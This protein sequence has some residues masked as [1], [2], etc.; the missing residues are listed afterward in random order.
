MSDV[1]VSYARPAER[2]AQQ[3]TDLL[4]SSGYSVWRDD[5]LPA[6]RTY[7]EVIEERLASAKAVLVL[8]SAD[9]FKSQWVRAEADIA[10]EAGTLVQ[11]TVDGK[12]PPLPFN[13]IQCAN[14]QNWN[15]NAEAAE[16]KKVEGSIASL[17]RATG[18]GSSPE[19][20]MD[21]KN[22]SIC[23]LPFENMS[24]DA[25]Q[26][27]FSD[28]I[29]EDIITDLSK[30]AAL[31]VVARNT[32]FSFKGKAMPVKDVA[33]MLDVTHVLEGSVRKAGTRVRITAQLIDGSAGHQLW[34]ERYDRD[35][36]DIFA[37]QDEISKAIVSALEVRLQ[38]KEKK[39]IEV[40]ETSSPE[41]YN[42][43]L[44][45]RRHW[46]SGNDGDS[47]RDE[48][49][50]RI[51]HQATAIDPNYARAWALMA[52]AQADLKFR[53]NKNADGLEAAERALSLD[54]NIAEAHCVK[55]RY[56]DAAGESEQAKERIETAISLNPESWET[57]KEAARL[58]FRHGKIE[59]ATPY[60][61][62][63]A[64]LMETDYNDT[65]M[66]ITCHH[67]LGHPEDL[68]RVAKMTLR[69][70]EQ[71][72]A[73]DPSNGSAVAAN[74][75]ALAALGQSDRAR[76]R[77]ERALL[78]DPD[79]LVARYNLACTL[80]AYLG[81][82]S[83]ALELLE[84]YFAQSGPTEIAHAAADPDMDPIRD[85]PGFKKMLSEA[86]TRV[87]QKAVAQ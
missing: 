67:A 85:D 9:A 66:L 36:T 24:G 35:L 50:V 53:H 3:I 4:R 12:L 8:W 63:A 5:E 45:A 2:E 18:A 47:R 61:E 31:T 48:I 56:L 71:A 21:E 49:V 32:S 70:T 15:G 7:G 83:G 84:P 41:A 26:E 78:I 34:A 55:A 79:N 82:T 19:Q 14:L 75:T 81:D 60:F 44:M 77:M 69:R 23:V 68:K 65:I 72:M 28:G 20:A 52:L 59:Q 76:E 30:V 39:A 1:F 42:L 43:Y 54:P 13:Q 40:R 17:I 74:A 10:R 22:L 37:I 58:N 33:A 46:I 29:S 87:T 11:V 57:N 62:K 51:C 16:W 64:S 38:P 27:Y 80:V 86:Q 73:Q 25:E 6:H